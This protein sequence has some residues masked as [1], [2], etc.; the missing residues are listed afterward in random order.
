MTPLKLRGHKAMAT[1]SRSALTIE[2]GNNGGFST[3]S[4]LIINVF[5]IYLA[6]STGR[7]FLIIARSKAFYNYK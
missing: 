1:E 3:S 2:F 6:G 5:V 4:G 7:A